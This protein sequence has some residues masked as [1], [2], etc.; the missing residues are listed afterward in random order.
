MSPSK[1]ILGLALRQG[2]RVK[3]VQDG[4][5]KVFVITEDKIKF[6]ARDK[7]TDDLDV[8]AALT[9]LPAVSPINIEDLKAR[10]A[11]ASKAGIRQTRT[12]RTSKT[13]KTIYRPL[14]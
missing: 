4:G 3:L 6:E 12:D 11:A 1:A 14:G 9:R 2:T 13:G 10:Y 7:V 5:E 8:V